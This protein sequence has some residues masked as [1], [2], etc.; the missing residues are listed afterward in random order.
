MFKALCISLCVYRAVGG[1]QTSVFYP[2]LT[3]LLLIILFLYW[4]IVALY[5]SHIIY[6]QISLHHSVLYDVADVIVLDSIVTLRF[7][8][9]ASTPTYRYLVTE[10]LTEQQRTIPALSPE[11]LSSGDKC[12]IDVCGDE[13]KGGGVGERGGREI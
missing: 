2:I 1:V 12:D 13:R 3:W 10:S 6:V 7:L 4:A 8:L 11:P 5:P 9:T